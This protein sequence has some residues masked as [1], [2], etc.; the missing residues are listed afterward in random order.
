MTYELWD[1]AS[2]NRIEGF[3]EFPEL[4]EIVRQIADLQGL[5]ALDDLFVEAWAALDDD[6]PVGTYRGDDLRRFVQPLIKT[7]A[8]DVDVDG[9]PTIPTLTR[10]RTSQATRT[11]KARVAAAV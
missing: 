4:V 7:Y 3:E 6:A 2:G 10:T 9:T 11:S 8:L 5:N 1:Q